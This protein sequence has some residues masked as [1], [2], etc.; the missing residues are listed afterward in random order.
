MPAGVHEIGAFDRTAESGAA[1]GAEPLAAAG[2]VSLGKLAILVVQVALAI[3]AIWQFQ[4]EGRAFFALALLCGV[5]F[6]IHALLPFAYRLPFFLVLSV[7]TV[8]WVLGAAP[9]VWVVGLTLLVVGVCHLPIRW[10]R[11]VV[12]VAAAGACLAVCRAGWLA[13]PW[14]RTMPRASILP[15]GRSKR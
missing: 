12:A 6:L 11:R 10:S 15:C 13:A 1:T 4:I 5:G 8:P 9:G 7:V 3:A 14:P 2:R